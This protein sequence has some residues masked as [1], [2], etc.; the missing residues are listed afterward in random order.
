VVATIDA[1]GWT[2]LDDDDLASRYESIV[3]E[4]RSR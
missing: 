4:V 1:G 3:A 2:R